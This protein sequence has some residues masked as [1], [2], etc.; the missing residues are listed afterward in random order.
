[1]RQIRRSIG[2]VRKTQQ[3]TKTMEM[4]AAAKIKRAQ[5]RIE[6]ARPYALKLVD[7]LEGLSTIVAGV[8]HP[9]LEQRLPPENVLVVVQASNRGLC[10]AFNSNILRKAEGIVERERSAGRG[11]EL[12]T[13]GKKAMSYFTYREVPIAANFPVGDAGRFDE[14]KP[15]ADY[16]VDRFTQRH[17]DEVYLVF[18]HFASMAR[19]LPTE[20]RLLPVQQQAEPET[21]DTTE[22][23]LE[24]IFEP[25]ARSVLEALLPTYIDTLVY[26]AV[27]ESVASEH[28]ARRAAMKAASDNADEMIRVLTLKLNKAR[29]AQITQ[30]LSEIVTSAEAIKHITEG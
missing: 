16:I 29:Q 14:A 28:A 13:L 8:E 11:V 12:V 2:G 22:M 23:M 5:Q 1:M 3:I 21:S 9:L 30:E 15:V 18:N 19:Q 10:G 4:V 24:Y 25:D 17:V 27:L 7:L 26:R 20:F 6:S